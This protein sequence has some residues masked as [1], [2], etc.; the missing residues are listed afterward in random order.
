MQKFKKILLIQTA[1][2]GDVILATP[3]IE[4]LK[5]FYPDAEIDFL[6]KKGNESLLLGHPKLHKVWLWDKSDKKNMRLLALISAIRE[7]KY[8]LVVNMQRFMS[9]GLLTAAS[10]AGQRIGFAKNPLS[11][12]FTKRIPHIINSSEFNHEIDRNLSLITSITD[13]SRFKPRL[14]PSS[15]DFAKV[16]SFKRQAYICIAPASLWFTKQLPEAKWVEFA[17]AFRI[18]YPDYMVYFIGGKAD[19]ALAD[20]IQSAA[21]LKNTANLCGQLGLLASAALLKDAQMNFVN[22]SSPAH[23]ATAMDAKVCEIY[24][25]TVPAFGFTALSTHT[26]IVEVKGLDCR[27]CGL[28]GHKKC[29]KGHFLCGN[30]I[31]VQEM[32]ASMAF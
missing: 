5:T 6:T 27:P 29:P 26:H 10:G 21:G 20:R 25:S 28:H 13:K 1:S 16:S 3:L 22:D 30:D 9:S 19:K 12:F 32:L 4:K 17:T 2:L 7:E 11:C 23:L 24:C 15:E 14:Y 18:E 8:D 31:D